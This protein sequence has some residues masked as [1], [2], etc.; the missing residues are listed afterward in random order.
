MAQV[1]G[2]NVNGLWRHGMQLLRDLGVEQDS[3]AG[4]V[5]VYPEPVMSVYD[6]PCERVLFDPLR[7]ANPFFHLMEALWMLSGDY[8][9]AFLDRYVGDFGQRFAEDAD[10]PGAYIHGAYGQRWRA[11]LGFDQL[12]EVVKKL[13]ANPDDRQCVIQ[14]WDGTDKPERL[15]GDRGYNDLR[16]AWRD[17]PCNTHVYLRVRSETCRTCGGSGFTGAHDYDGVCANCG[18][19]KMESPPQLDLTVC[20]RSNDIVWGA[21]GA[22]AV[23][24]SVL[25]EYLAGRI[26]VGVGKMYQLSNN[27]HGYVDVLKRFE[28]AS[29]DGNV[30]LYVGH[31][32]VRPMPIGDRWNVWDADLHR[33]MHWHDDILWQD[34]AAGIVDYQNDWFRDVATPVAVT[35]YLWKDRRRDAAMQCVEGIRANDWHQACRAWM[36]RRMAR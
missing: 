14:M 31:D 6:R 9:S 27:F 3:R 29:A 33:F 26:G 8:E 35:N 21:Y 4:R 25:Q 7:D 11:A 10:T 13:R 2:R 22:N 15:A 18:G 30:D 28:G 19:Q 16:G 5:L 36:V 12:D 1:G 23:H 34:N 20:C 24:F 32:V 17:R